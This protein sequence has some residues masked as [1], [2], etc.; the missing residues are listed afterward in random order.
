[1]THSIQP[2]PVR[3]RSS[4]VALV[5]WG[6]V[7]GLCGV[8][9]RAQVREIPKPA[10]VVPAA[11]PEP[12]GPGGFPSAEVL[13]RLHGTTSA[14]VRS[15]AVPAKVF[16]TPSAIVAAAVSVHAGGGVLVRGESHAGDRTTLWRAAA[17]AVDELKKKLPDGNDALTEQARRELVAG[18][19]VTLEIAGDPVPIKPNGYADVDTLVSMGVDGVAVR[20]G[21]TIEFDFP[22]AMLAREVTPGHALAG[23]AGRVIGDASRTLP[24]DPAAQP[25]KLGPQEH[26]TWYRVPV[27]VLGPPRADV[28]PAFLFRGGRVIDEGEITSVELARAADGLAKHLMARRWPGKE[29]YGVRGSYMPVQGRYA[30]D[31]APP[32][33]QGLVLLA[34]RAYADTPGV[35]GKGKASAE[36]ARRELVQDLCFVEPGE[37]EPCANP[38]NAMAVLAGVGSLCD[39]AHA[40]GAEARALE[41]CV[42]RMLDGPVPDE[43]VGLRALAATTV[44]DTRGPVFAMELAR[45]LTA[46][47]YAK[48]PAGQLPS[49]MPWLVLADLASAEAGKPL[50]SAAA[51]REFR[52]RVYRY[53]VRP[54]DCDASTRDLAGAIVF[55][56]E[57]GRTLLASWQSARPVAGLAAMLGDPR[58]TPD[59]EFG[60]E[61]ARLLPSL[62]FLRQLCADEAIGRLYH[63][64]ARAMWGARAAPWEQRMPGE[65]S[66]LTLLTFCET[67]KSLEAYRLRHAR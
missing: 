21:E 23:C 47:A 6:A 51:L 14:W 26:L 10:G 1:M 64:P 36:A 4:P 9:A 53:Q 5:A 34:L 38:G 15:L 58:V 41:A 61:L 27:Q 45:R 32:E 31:F 2:R 54:E 11:A 42:R 16:E 25:G 39:N 3:L 18:A 50:A 67:L 28:G 44:C 59:E 52:E 17:L 30:A 57:Q 13:I 56:T 20:R 55:T 46:E 48:T 12:N 40:M 29:K 19:T 33:E 43:A 22:E 65:A 60:A 62:R 24:M 66:A 7:I 8:G 63:D 35:D 37:A 49:Q